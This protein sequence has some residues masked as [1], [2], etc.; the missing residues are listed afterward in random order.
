MT[1][2]INDV[3]DKILSKTIDK[4]E[5]Q[6]SFESLSDEQKIQL[7]AEIRLKMPA[8]ETVESDESAEPEAPAEQAPRLLSS[9][10]ELGLSDHH[11]EYIAELTVD[12]ENYVPKSKG[13]ALKHQQ[14]FVDQRKTAGLKNALKSIQF[15]LTYEKADGPYLYDIDGHEYID[16]AGDNGV[17]LFGHQPD[18]MKKALSERL[19]KGYPL[20]GYSEDLFE[21][22]RLFT[23]ITGHE[24]VVFAQSGTE[25]VMW[26]V[27]IARAATL[28]KK[29]VTFEGSYHGLSDAVLAF[30]DRKGNTMAAGLGML[31]EFAEQLIILDFGKMED[32]KVI[33]ER[34]DEIAC[35]LCEPVQSR[36]PALQPKEFVKELRKVTME[37]NVTLIFDEMI[38]GLRACC[39]GAEGFYD[40]KPDIGVYGKIPGGGMPTGVIAGAAK[41][42]DYVDGGTWNFD[43]KSMPKLKRTF[44]A[45]THTQNP[46]KVSACLAVLTELKNRCKA[47]PRC[48]FHTCFLSEMNDRTERLS[49][50][51]NE[52]FAEVRVP[53]E[54]DYFSSLFR[55]KVSDDEFGMVRELL[56]VL[57]KMNGVETSTSGNNFLTTQHT[58]EHCQRVMDAVK[59]A[60][61]ILIEKGFFY[62]AEEVEEVEAAVVAAPVAQVAAPATPVDQSPADNYQAAQLKNLIIADLQNFQAGEA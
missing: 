17:N 32:L 33:E 62:Q 28:K 58:D 1:S 39:R 7:L 41:Y 46:F 48:D 5:A 59:I 49:N 36:F 30:R 25:A 10:H 56:I 51:M 38:T 52:Y 47:E 11:K 2:P 12:F 18:F 16:L 43:D 42:M 44:M 50:Q 21:A 37:N 9:V 3:I 61:A 40:V 15:Q 14:Y 29:I 26:A 54:V 45:G 57:L 13:N 27:R 6:A 4:Q 53:I 34:A 22:A 55:F 60:T 8:D 23:E 35:V 31:Q 24:R 19:E 20:V